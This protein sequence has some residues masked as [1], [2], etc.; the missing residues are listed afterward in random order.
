ME[1]K[2]LSRLCPSEAW[3]APCEE[4]EQRRTSQGEI[5]YVKARRKRQTADELKDIEGNGT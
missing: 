3:D 1:D 4:W 2:V 5:Q